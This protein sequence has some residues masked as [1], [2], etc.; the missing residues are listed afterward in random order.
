MLV[1]GCNADP[2]T[3]A[4]ALMSLHGSGAGTCGL[5]IRGVAVESESGSSTMGVL[6]G[7][8][9]L[10]SRLRTSLDEDALEPT[11]TTDIAGTETSPSSGSSSLDF[12]S[13]VDL[14]LS[15]E[16]GEILDDVGCTFHTRSGSRMLTHRASSCG[17]LETYITTGVGNRCTCC[18]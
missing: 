18:A 4:A 5:Y 11:G 1:K 10:R 6:R 9:A 7:G 14:D 15:S 12:F 16:G 2:A 13:G 17:R 3:K 8:V